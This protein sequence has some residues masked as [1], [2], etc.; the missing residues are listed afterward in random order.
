VPTDSLLPPFDYPGSARSRTSS[1]S[2]HSHDSYHHHHLLS[3]TSTSSHYSPFSDFSVITPGSFP[4][5]ESSQH[6]LSHLALHPEPGPSNLPFD[7][8][9]FS[10]LSPS[11]RS[12]EVHSGTTFEPDPLSHATGPE[13]PSTSTSAVMGPDMGIPQGLGQR[14]SSENS[15]DSTLRLSL[16][17]A[18]APALAV[19]QAMPPSKFPIPEIPEDR[20]D[21]DDPVPEYTGTAPNVRRRK[22]EAISSAPLKQCFM[23]DSLRRR[24]LLRIL[25]KPWLREHKLEPQF[26]SEDDDVTTGLEIQVAHAFGM[27]KGDS[28]FKAFEGQAGECPFDGCPN[29]ETRAHRRISHVRTHFGLRPFAC[30]PRGCSRCQARIE[31]GLECVLTI[32]SL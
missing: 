3:P 31:R 7:A 26:L 5:L 32:W 23:G 21:D 27:K 28:L 22:G 30:N 14:N 18:P 19:D 1:I 6:M 29:L 13:G 16:Y 12:H 20:D 17:T 2:S 10:T 15:S 9:H 11:K 24:L 4:D 8:H 25:A